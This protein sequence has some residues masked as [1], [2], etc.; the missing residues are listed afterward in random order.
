M[1]LSHQFK[2][3]QKNFKQ[4]PKGLKNIEIADTLEVHR[5]TV[6]SWLKRYKQSGIKVLKARKVGR[7][8]GSGMQLSAKV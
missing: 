1:L 2:I 6:S 8:V 7:R 4:S 3:C 5:S